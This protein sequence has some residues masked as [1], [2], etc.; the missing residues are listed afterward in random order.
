MVLCYDMY[1]STVL[2]E[3][4]DVEVCRDETHLYLL[5]HPTDA[6]VQGVSLYM[7]STS[8]T[9]ST[10][11]QPVHVV[12]EVRHSVY[13]VELLAITSNSAP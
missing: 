6:E 10:T 2:V 12:A 8:T 5:M 1:W 9:S 4:V 11:V 13:K 3:V 7:T